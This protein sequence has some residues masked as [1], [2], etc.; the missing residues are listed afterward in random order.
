M[1]FGNSIK[2]TQDEEQTILNYIDKIK[3][4][5]NGDTNKIVFNN[6]EVFNTK[7]IKNS[8][9]ELSTLLMKK[10]Q[11]DLIIQSEI[12]HFLEKVSNGH[13]SDK[14]NSAKSINQMI[15]KMENNFVSINAILN[16]YKNEN[17]INSIDKNIYRGGELFKLIEGINSLQEVL[18]KTLNSNLEHGLKLEENSIKLHKKLS[19]LSD[20]IEEQVLVLD[21]TA[22]EVEKITTQTKLNTETTMQMQNSSLELKSSI[23]NGNKLA[24]ETVDAMKF[25]NDSTNAINDA[26]EIIDQISFQTNI[27]SLNAAVEAAT[28]GEAGKGFAVVAQEVRNLANRSADA[29]KDIKQ[30]V[31]KATTYATTGLNI[32]DKMITG[33]STLHKNIDNTMDLINNIATASQEQVTSITQINE[34]LATLEQK[35]NDYA[36]FT[37]DT[38][39]ISAITEAIATKIVS[40]VKLKEFDG[41]E[42]VLSSFKK[43]L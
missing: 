18:T 10:S 12:M 20:A 34:T 27:L 1:F 8:L 15:E 35:T 33:Y 6:I 24:L 26:I 31:S 25:I 39:E 37:K 29:A 3:E 14:S 16:E 30:L 22:S 9:D 40:D 11:D 38:N 43:E 4:F 41:K 36:D 32:S 5:V 21:S 42:I 13:N 23:E 19:Y 2:I 17:Y 7:K 28:A